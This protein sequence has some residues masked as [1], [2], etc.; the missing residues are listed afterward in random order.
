MIFC[1]RDTKL[2]IE[3]ARKRKLMATMP[4]TAGRALRVLTV[5]SCALALLGATLGSSPRLLKQI[6]YG[7]YGSKYHRIGDLDGDGIPDLLLVQVTA[8]GG[9]DKAIIT[10]LTALT[11]DGK[12]LWQVGKPDPKN[13]YFGGDF[14]VQIYDQDGDGNNEVLYIEDERNVLTILD[15]MTGARKRT[16]QLAGGHD[17]ILFVDFEG[18]G[19]A[20]DL[21]VKDRYKS[22]WVYDRDFRL[23]WSKKDVNP[24]HFPMNYDVDGDGKDEL[25]MGYTLYRH[26][27]KELWSHPEFPLH[28]DAVYIEDM[29]GDGKAEIAIATSKDAVLLDSSGHVLF[30]YPMDHCQHALIGKFRKDLPGEQVFFLS[31]MDE[32]PNSQFRFAQMVLMT[33]KGEVLWKKEKQDIWYTGAMRV[34]RWTSDPKLQHVALYS[35]GFAPPA[36]LDGYGNELAR[37]PFNAALKLLGGGPS[38][39]DLYDDYYMQHLDLFGDERE[40]LL[41]FNHKSLYVYAN[42]APWQRPR[43]YN[44]TYYPGRL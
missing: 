8:P 30:R 40:E 6:D 19:Y 34:D 21:V 1:N 10:C 37:L 24:G 15:G 33:T 4:L 29:D 18:T 39:K 12:R 25:L 3:N 13:I 44:N 41:V 32:Q 38:G 36:L 27:G 22:F 26:D 16:V 43:L 35:R 17:S 31:R 14:P 28:N 9:E 42:G 11:L 7:D 20:R 5:L 23:R 2:A